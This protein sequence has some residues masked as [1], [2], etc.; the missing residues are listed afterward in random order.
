MCLSKVIFSI[1][2]PH[3]KLVNI[4]SVLESKL[5]GLKEQTNPQTVRGLTKAISLLQ[6]R[7]LILPALDVV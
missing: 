7:N 1:A 6:H 2:A 4:A 3:H 5:F